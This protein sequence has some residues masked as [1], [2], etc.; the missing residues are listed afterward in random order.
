MNYTSEQAATVLNAVR[1]VLTTPAPDNLKLKNLW[2]TLLYLR[3]AGLT[4]GLHDRIGDCVYAGPFKGM[5]LTPSVMNTNLAPHLL[6]CYEHELHEMIEEIAATPYRH[7]LNIGCSYGYYSIGL[8]MR[9]PQVI[10]HSFDTSE[11]ARIQCKEMSERNGVAERIKIGGEFRGEDFAAYADARTLAIVD[12]EGA[13]KNLLDPACYPALQNLDILV[14]MHDCIDKDMS[15]I[16]T[17]R[18]AGTHDITL[19]RNQSFL[20]PFEDI[21]EPPNYVD[22][23]DKLIFT[24]EMRDGPTPWAMMKAKSI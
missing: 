10:M 4:R 7:I 16:I 13:E 15:K 1:Q 17:D 22:P 23:F 2:Y 21:L 9:M 19:I 12:I 11:D 14:E 18:F 3:S 8:A 24:W 20:Y 5:R 6:G